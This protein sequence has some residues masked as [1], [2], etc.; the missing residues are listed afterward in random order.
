MTEATAIYD[1]KADGARA[2]AE[3]IRMLRER[4]VRE[5]RYQPINDHERAIAEKANA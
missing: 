2:Y 4:G 1:G 3:A 5:G